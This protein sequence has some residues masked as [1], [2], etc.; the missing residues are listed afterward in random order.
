VNA[1]ELLAGYGLVALVAATTAVRVAG[2]F[3]YRLNAYRIFHDLRIR[4]SLVRRARLRELTGFSIYSSIIDWANKLN[5]QLDQLVIGAMLGSTAVAVW[6]PAERI[7]SGTQRLT[8]QANGVL[9]PVIV[10]NDTTRKQAQLQQILLRGTQISLAMVVPIAISL[11]VL[12]DPLI[13]AWL[14]A[15][16]ADVAGSIPVIQILSIAV[17]IRV[18]NATASTLLKGAGRHRLVAFANLGTGVVNVGLSLLLIRPYGLVGVAIGTLIPIALS[19]IGIIQPAAYRH[20]GIPVRRGFVQSVVPALW[21]AAVAG[22]LLAFTRHISSGT[23]LAVAAQAAAAGA[24]Y[25]GLFAW[26]IRREDRA[27]YVAKVLQLT[28]RAGPRP[29]A[30]PLS[31]PAI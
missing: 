13:R 14:G 9:F 16:A 4:P 19:T 21:P 11:F 29:P 3:V 12:A 8:N 20:V 23:F 15:R 7:I 17:A 6:A 2:Y 30:G 5:Y 28:R 22:V 26:A 1:A 27:Y 31:E 25:L 10:D 24:L 18:G